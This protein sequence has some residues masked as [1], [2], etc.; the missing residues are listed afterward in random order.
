MNPFILILC[1]ALVLG[2]TTSNANPIQLSVEK[3]IMAVQLLS[4]SQ[5]E[6]SD[7]ARRAKLEKSKSILVEASLLNPKD[8]E[9]RA[10]IIDVR[11]HLMLI[12]SDCCSGSAK[13][14]Q[15][16][17][18]YSTEMLQLFPNSPEISYVSSKVS[19]LLERIE[20][21]RRTLQLSPEHNDAQF[22][23]S[24]CLIES[25]SAKSLNEAAEIAVDVIKRSIPPEEAIQIGQYYSSKL[26]SA[27]KFNDI[28]E[29]I[30]SR[31]A[32]LDDLR[33]KK[34]TSSLKK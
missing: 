10:M 16:I 24:A 17:L 15:E 13:E 28:L 9:I 2:L 18:A 5:S 26:R 34:S 1:V 8:P 20:L 4:D 14:R 23:L 29:A 32:E 21:L 31:K 7:T 27:A 3:R 33:S 19:P 12:D 30:E 22:D 25:G 11:Y 6:T